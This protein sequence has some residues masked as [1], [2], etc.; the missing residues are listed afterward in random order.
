MAVCVGERE[1]EREREGEGGLIM[2]F[3]TL[4]LSQVY[5]HCEIRVVWTSTYV[6]CMSQETQ[7]LHA[8]QLDLQCIYITYISMYTIKRI[9]MYV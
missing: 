2:T 7:V 6:N 8:V 4:S 9:S 3:Q 5:Q 1:R